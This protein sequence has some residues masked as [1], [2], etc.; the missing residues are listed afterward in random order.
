MA[1]G[2]IQNNSFM[3]ELLHG[4][5]P[6]N[7]FAYF[8]VPVPG[9]IF[10]FSTNANVLAWPDIELKNLAELASN[11]PDPNCNELRNIIAQR[12]NISPEN[13]LFTNGTNEAIFLLAR[14]LGVC[15]TGILQPAYS[16]YERAFTNATDFFKLNLAGDFDAVIFSNPN[17]PTGIYIK[18]VYEFAKKFPKTIFI[19][20]EAYIDFVLNSEIPP[21]KIL[22]NIIILRSLT[23]IF[24]LSGARIGYV[25]ANENVI[26]ELKK[27][28]P[29]WSVNNFAQEL[30]RK[31]LLNQDFYN[32]TRNFYKK[33]TPEFI[34]MI[35][36]AGYEVLNTDVHYFLI[37]VEDDVK[38]IRK[39]LNYGV[40]VRHTRN[41]KTL[42]RKFIRI[43]TQ[44]PRENKFL[45]EILKN[46][47]SKKSWQKIKI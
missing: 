2:I 13:I 31:F 28:L 47:E 9:K 46:L 17:N 40:V 36:S 16:E 24:K 15:R 5:N 10:D 8:K 3:I 41:F 12:E 38:I 22:D 26:S 11:Y 20:D 37:K 18:N 19:I 27:F 21:L 1:R 39:L 43:A 32:A 7:L 44:Q 33:H 6:E 30:A 35:K 34:N 23:K 45:A 25:I 4:A 29:S 42:D 14:L